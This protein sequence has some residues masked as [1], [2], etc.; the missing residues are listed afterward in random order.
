MNAYNF[1]KNAIIRGEIL[2]G[3]R[4]AEESLAKEMGVSRTP[5]REAIKQLEVEGLVT[6]LKRGVKVREFTKDD[7]KQIYDI[8]A[9]LEGYA[10]SQA[11]LN[12][13][14]EHI[15]QMKRA[16]SFLENA[17]VDFEETDIVTTDDIVNSNKKFHD[18]VTAASKNI[19]I[20]F[21]ISKVVVLPL[22]FRS[23]HGSGPNQ[24]RRSLDF[25]ETIITAIENEEPDRARTAM[26]EHILK[27]RDHVLE[28]MKEEK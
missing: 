5:I 18:T 28:K 3:M 11:A 24:L 8:R 10:A 15:Y 1:I 20:E 9:L 14:T 16:N 26:K 13:T 23:F 21:H 6:P 7:I 17:I 22:V 2:P 27:G 12:R 4:L 25:H 19:H